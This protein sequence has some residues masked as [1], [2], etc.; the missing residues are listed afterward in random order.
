MRV[1]VAIRI[2][3]NES[4]AGAWFHREMKFD[5]MPMKE[6]KFEFAL[7]GKGMPNYHKHELFMVTEVCWVEKNNTV[8]IR[9]ALDREALGLVKT[10][11]FDLRVWKVG[12]P[13]P[14]RK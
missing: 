6:M 7:K 9:L 4:G 8:Y 2:D 11:D 3:I 13:D 12:E 14:W 10:S 5:F 1:I